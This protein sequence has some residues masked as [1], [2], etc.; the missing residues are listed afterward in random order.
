MFQA[1]NERVRGWW[2]A[3]FSAA[4]C[5][6][7]FCQVWINPGSCQLWL[8]W[9]WQRVGHGRC[10]STV[11]Y[12]RHISCAAGGK[13]NLVA[14]MTAYSIRLCYFL[15]SLAELDA[16]RH[17]VTVLAR[18]DIE[19]L[20]RCIH[21]QLWD[22]LDRLTLRGLTFF[23][24]LLLLLSTSISVSETWCKWLQ[25]GSVE[26][27]TQVPLS[28]SLMGDAGAVKTLQDTPLLALSTLGQCGLV[29][30]ACNGVW[31]C[32]QRKDML[33]VCRGSVIGQFVCACSLL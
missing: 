5:C 17:H 16:L 9:R 27:V 23:N 1:W 24:F 15:I 2:N 6:V 14:G 33:Y 19:W 28:R 10:R 4:A 20:C 30:A 32:P 25:A 3:S 11:V 31:I 7:C 12:D 26:C 13:W 8:G 22:C 18:L 29:C 21:I